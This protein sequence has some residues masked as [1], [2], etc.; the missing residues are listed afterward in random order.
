MGKVLDLKADITLWSKSSRA[1]ARMMFVIRA[2]SGRV[3]SI[4]S[5]SITNQQ[6]LKKQHVTWLES[7]S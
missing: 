1:F 5:R 3:T 6:P 7:Q 4:R 2:Y